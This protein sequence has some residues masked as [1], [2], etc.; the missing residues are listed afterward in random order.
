MPK[1][2]DGSDQASVTMG[3]RTPPPGLRWNASNALSEESAMPYHSD[4]GTIFAAAYRAGRVPAVV[5]PMSACSAQ[6][7]N[8]PMP[9]DMGDH[10]QHPYGNMWGCDGHLQVPGDIAAYWS[11]LGCHDS[12]ATAAF[13]MAA[14]GPAVCTTL[15]GR[16]G[17]RDK[18]GGSVRWWTK[19]DLPL[20]CP[21]TRFPVTLLPYPP[22]KFRVDPQRS[23][24]HRLVDGK[25]LAM[26]LIV[27]G[28]FSACG[29]DLLQSD[30]NALDD[31]VHRCKLGP[32][33]PGRAL[34]LAREVASPQTH[35]ERRVQAAQELE[36]LTAST[37]TELGKLR[38]I[39]ENRLMQ[40]NKTGSSQ[41]NRLSS[42]S[43]STST[44]T[45]ASANDSPQ[46]DF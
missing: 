44:S 30:I 17:R 34:A 25:F 6:D 36:S 1:G 43:S 38:R 28:R 15:S 40:L 20:L 24:P 2:L 8:V 7:A 9:E 13:E 41:R 23:S 22:F 32:Y 31:Y 35:P 45:R 5:P 16:H 46:C 10:L 11:P 26:Q 19:P 29:R 39:Q 21:L 12:D 37:R 18:S 4:A 3:P 42:G 33:R 14:F 27:S